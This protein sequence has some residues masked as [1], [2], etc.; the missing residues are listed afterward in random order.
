VVVVEVVP[1]LKVVAAADLGKGLAAP[2][3]GALVGFVRIVVRR[4][5]GRSFARFGAADYSST[6]YSVSRDSP[7]QN[8]Q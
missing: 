3:N 1:W 4:H 2:R 7:V 6:K 5:R 8:V